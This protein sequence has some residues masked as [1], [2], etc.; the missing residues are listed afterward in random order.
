M[1]FSD[2]GAVRRHLETKNVV[3]L[4]FKNFFDCLSVF[5]PHDITAV[6]LFRIFV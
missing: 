5:K 1:F 4:T 2:D 6:L 3:Y